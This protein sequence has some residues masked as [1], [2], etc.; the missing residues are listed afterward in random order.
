M[1]AHHEGQRDLPIYGQR[2]GACQEPV[3]GR[4]SIERFRWTACMIGP[5]D[6]DQT[7]D[8]SDLSRETSDCTVRGPNIK[9]CAGTEVALYKG[10]DVIHHVW[11]VGQSFEKGFRRP[12]SF[13]FMSSRGDVLAVV[14]G[15]RRFPE[16]MA[17]DTQSYD[18]I[19][20][21][22]ACA[23]IGK[24]IQAVEGMNP[25]IAFRV[26][27]RILRATLKCCEFRIEAKPTALV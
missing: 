8:A 6:T 5:S 21:F 12:D 9:E 20:A 27:A 23:F 16:V 2:C 3:S 19:I 7:I 25:D 11:L 10:D 18:Q 13:R 22:M 1:P 26:P 17:E 4:E 14:F 24:P 15:R